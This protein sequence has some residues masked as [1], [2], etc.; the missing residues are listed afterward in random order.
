M[1]DYI[2]LILGILCVLYIL[3]LISESIIITN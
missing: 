2:N 3:K 1:T